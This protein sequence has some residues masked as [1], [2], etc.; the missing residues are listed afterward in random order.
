MI[1]RM[2]TT[3][4]M[5][6]VKRYLAITL[7]LLCVCLNSHAEQQSYRIEKL[8]ENL[9]AAIARTGSTAT[10]NAFFLVGDTYVVAG[11]AHMTRQ[12]SADLVEAISKVTS[13]PLRFFIL[14]HHHPGYTSVDFD[15]PKEVDVIMTLPVWG[16][17]NSEVRDI[18][19]PVIFYSDGLTLKTGSNTIIITNMGKAHSTGD[20]MVYFPEAKVLFTSDLVYINSVGYLGEGHMEDWVL[21]L[22]FMMQFDAE[23]IIPGHGP[24][25]SKDAIIKYSDFLRAFLSEIIK[26]IEAGDSLE[27]TKDSFSLPRYKHLEGYDQLLDLNI[28]RAY[29]NLKK[30]LN[31]G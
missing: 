7:L 26:H 17:L 13:K 14:P 23:N 18:P 11:G 30:S 31:K 9:Y 24:V 28:E 25:S 4:E 10:S 1:N 16:N 27:K 12:A 20:S 22:D 6:R 8:S 15:L 19:Y 3:R 5:T 29:T 21:S 2:V